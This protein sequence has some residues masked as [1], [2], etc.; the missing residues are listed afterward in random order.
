MWHVIGGRGCGP[1]AAASNGV[2]PESAGG[3]GIPAPLSVGRG[4]WGAHA[5]GVAG[6]DARG[7]LWAAPAGG[8]GLLDGPEGGESAGRAGHCSDVV[9]GGGGGRG[10]LVSRKGKE[11]GVGWGGGAGAHGGEEPGAAERARD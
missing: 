2:T 8:S 1:G 6:D 5:S 4:V 11:G 10:R 9:A 3:D 7:E